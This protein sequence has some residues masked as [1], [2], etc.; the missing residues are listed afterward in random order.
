M[1]FINKKG[2]VA[3]FVIIAIVIVA[4][5]LAFMFYPKINIGGNSETGNPKSFIESCM[6][7]DVNTL[8][9]ELSYN[10]GYEEPEG[11]IIYQGEKVPYFCY[12]SDSYETC[13]VQQP[14]VQGHFENEIERILKPSVES[15]VKDF[16]KEF[17]S[18]GYSVSVSKAE[19]NASFV[20]GKLKIELMSPMTLSKDTSRTYES[21][22]YEFKSDLY[23]LMA[24]ATSIIDYESVYGDSETTL[25]LRYYPNIK[26]EKVRLDEGSKIYTISNFVSGERFRFASRSLVWPPGFEQ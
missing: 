2:Q 15:C 6:K 19:L 11:F 21:F 4:I 8:L 23:D 13:I 24:L 7:E 10:G 20:P 9:D 17:E 25:Y 3:I 5:I 16:K 22:D 14:N 12:T 18:K 1:G 26:I